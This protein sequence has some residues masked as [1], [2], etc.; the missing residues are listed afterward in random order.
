[1]VGAA[2]APAEAAL[3]KPGIANGVIASALAALAACAPQSEVTEPKL[4]E[5]RQHVA[6]SRAA[7]EQTASILV[8]SLVAWANRESVRYK[9]GSDYQTKSWD[10]AELAPILKTELQAFMPKHNVEAIFVHDRRV[11]FVLHGAG[12]APSGVSVGVIVAA[13][14][15]H[16]CKS[17]ASRLK[18]GG[19]GLSCEKLGNQVYLYVQR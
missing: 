14:D 2:C 13:N 18:L 3:V 9:A 19:D 10:A 15:E 6:G 4:E 5:I 11:N 12:I 8:P 1:M 7:F 17:I 16:G